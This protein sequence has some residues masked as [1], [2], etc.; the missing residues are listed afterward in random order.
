MMR[1][2]TLF[3][4]LLFNAPLLVTSTVT[5]GGYVIESRPGHFGKLFFPPGRNMAARLQ[6]LP[7]NAKLCN[8]IDEEV[9][10]ALPGLV[11]PTDNYTGELVVCS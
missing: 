5:F 2:Q 3:A 6:F 1:C 7:E 11:R 9:M 4:V 10:Q 8:G